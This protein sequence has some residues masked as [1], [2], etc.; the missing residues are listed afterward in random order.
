MYK[1]LDKIKCYVNNIQRPE[2]AAACISALST[3]YATKYTDHTTAAPTCPTRAVYALQISNYE[4]LSLTESWEPSDVDTCADLAAP[5]TTIS[6]N[7][8][9]RMQ[10]GDYMIQFVDDPT[11]PEDHTKSSG[12][13]EYMFDICNTIGMKPLCDYG[14]NLANST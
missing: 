6:A 7:T 2:H 5:S 9:L 1:S 4:S 12:Y 3:D 8:S 14:C 10:L 11:T 13:S